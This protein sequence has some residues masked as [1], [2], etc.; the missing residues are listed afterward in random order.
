MNFSLIEEAIT[1]Y[2]GPRCD[3]YMQ[4]CPCCDAWKTLDDIKLF[5]DDLLKVKLPK[6]GPWDYYEQT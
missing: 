4:G 6:D 3:D 1:D 5:I 2:Y